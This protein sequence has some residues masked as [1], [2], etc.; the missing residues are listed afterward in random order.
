MEKAKAL[1]KI[2]Y[3]GFRSI[4]LTFREIVDSYDWDMSDQL[5]I[6]DMH[7]NST[8]E[9]LKYAGSKGIPIC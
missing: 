5:N 9:G 3:I 8:V 6:M 7:N 1:G 2:R 4:M